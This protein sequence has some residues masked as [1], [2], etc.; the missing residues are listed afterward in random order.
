MA[1]SDG[2]DRT[3]T[4]FFLSLFILRERE[5]ERESTSGGGAE[6]RDRIP[7]RL[8]AISAEPDAGLELTNCDFMT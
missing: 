2:C 3:V 1:C 6:R 8:R 7:G 4:Y 5:R